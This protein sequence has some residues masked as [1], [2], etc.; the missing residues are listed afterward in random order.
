IR[1]VHSMVDPCDPAF[2]SY[3]GF[4]VTTNDATVVK[5]FEPQTHRPAAKSMLTASGDMK[6]D[7][8]FNR[9]CK[10]GPGEYNIRFHYLEH[11]TPSMPIEIYPSHSK[12]ARRL[13]A[14]GTR[15]VKATT[16][17]TSERDRK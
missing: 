10:L 17:E 13:R 6:V 8:L 14:S 15:R 5:D 12:T 7:L 4:R 11:Q 1:D 3:A 9:F 2:A 16:S